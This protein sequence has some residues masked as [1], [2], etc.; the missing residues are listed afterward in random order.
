MSSQSATKHKVSSTDVLPVGVSV[1]SPGNGA[2]VVGAKGVGVGA[3]VRKLV[4]AVD[5]AVVVG[6]RV[7][8]VVGLTE[9]T[10]S[11]ISVDAFMG[12]SVGVFVGVSEDASVA[13]SLLQLNGQ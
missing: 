5:G 6:A 13:H 1:L 3:G 10:L 9:G 7:G 4:G 11:G 8:A 2:R 12:A